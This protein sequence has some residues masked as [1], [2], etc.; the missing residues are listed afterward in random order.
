MTENGMIP[1]QDTRELLSE[2]SVPEIGALVAEMMRPVLAALGTMVQNN[3]EAMER[4]AVL[5]NMQFDRLEEI[6]RR[7]RMRS[8]VTARQ[9]KFL[10][11]AAKRRARELLDKRDLSEDTRAVKKLA[12]CIRQ[13]VLERCGVG[14]LKEI[15]EQEYS[16][17]L[18]QIGMWSDALALRD[19]VKEARNR[20]EA[21][22]DAP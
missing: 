10:S 4:M 5:Q 21:D 6:E 15:P 1:A 22:P 7:I 9:A 3:T 16:V 12:S 18:S 19:V 14:S 20:A 11:D 17:S 13:S 8:P 2:S